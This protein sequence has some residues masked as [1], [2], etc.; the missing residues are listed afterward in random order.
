MLDVYGDYFNGTSGYFY[1]VAAV[2]PA[3][4]QPTV[5]A[6]SPACCNLQDVPT[7]AEIDVQYS[8]PLDSTTVTTSNFFQNTGPA[9]TYTVTLL[10]GNT[11]VQIKPAHV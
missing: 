5:V 6:V 8:L 11:V 9:I 10:P 4:A 1:T 7:N 2:N 3:T